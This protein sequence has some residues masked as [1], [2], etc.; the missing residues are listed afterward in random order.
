MEGTSLSGRTF[1]NDLLLPLQATLFGMEGAVLPGHPEYGA[2]LGPLLL[3]LCAGLPLDWRGFSLVQK[4]MLSRLL[5]AVLAGWLIWAIAAH[6]AVEAA[7]ARHYFGLFPAWAVLAAAGYSSAARVRWGVVRLRRVLAALVGLA[8]CLAALSSLITFSNQ[9]PLPVVL[10]LQ[11]P[12]A[13]LVERLGMVA[14]AM[15][16]VD[17]LPPEARLLLLWEPR[18][19]YCPRDCL[20]DLRLANWEILRAQAGTTNPS[21]P[22]TAEAIE[23][24]L[25]QKGITHLLVYEAGRAQM[26]TSTL[27]QE[28]WR[29]FV[30]NH[31]VPIKAL[32]DSYALYALQEADR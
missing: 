14:Y 26:Q 24:L 8:L 13:Y 22:Q 9:N 12:Q 4:G 17:D 31:L 2:S 18:A 11:S 23:S 28:T 25:R 5:A 15:Q 16:A 27:D 19:Y 1:W 7:Y 29:V 21:P 6:Y 3:A 30:E 20:A 32:G 10:G